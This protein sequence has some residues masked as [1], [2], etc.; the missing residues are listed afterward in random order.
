GEDRPDRPLRTHYSYNAAHGDGIASRPTRRRAGLDNS[1][2]RIRGGALGLVAAAGLVA[3]AAM[4]LQ[5]GMLPG[6]PAVAA[7]LALAGYVAAAGRDA[8]GPVR[9]PV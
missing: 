6:P 1:R 5:S 9:W 8:P 4:G 7:L 3:G 2:M